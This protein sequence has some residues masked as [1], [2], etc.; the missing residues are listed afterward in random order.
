M[1]DFRIKTDCLSF[2]LI[3]TVGTH[4]ENSTLLKIP[5]ISS[6]SVDQ[7]LFDLP[8]DNFDNSILISFDSKVSHFRVSNSQIIAIF[9]PFFGLEKMMDVFGQINSEG[10]HEQ[11]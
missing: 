3:P 11:F 1:R 7:A 2:D 10:H 6:R 8:K 5:K 9:G 4:V